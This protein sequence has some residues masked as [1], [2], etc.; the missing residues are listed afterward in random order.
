MI[1]MNCFLNLYLFSMILTADTLC[2]V[3]QKT[4]SL[5][6]C[7]QKLPTTDNN[8]RVDTLIY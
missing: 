1:D 5:P 2:T 4:T 7:Q 6:L 8:K 3:E